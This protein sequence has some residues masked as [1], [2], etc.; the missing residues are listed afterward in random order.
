[1]N[2]EQLASKAEHIVR[3]SKGQP[4]ALPEKAQQAC[5]AYAKIK[6]TMTTKVLSAAGAYRGPVEVLAQGS[7][8]CTADAGAGVLVFCSATRP[9]GGWLTGAMAQEEAVSRASTWALSCDNPRFYSDKGND[10]YFYKNAV[11]SVAGK[12]F[13]RNNT[14]LSKPALVHFVGMCAPNARAMEEHHQHPESPAM[15]GRIV[16]ALVLRMRMALQAFAQAECSTIVLGAVGCGVF[17]VQLEDCV[18]A[19]DKALRLDGAPFERV[20]F[21]L[22]PNPSADMKKAFA[23]LGNAFVPRASEA[24]FGSP[25][26]GQ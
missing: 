12:V 4:S 22:G 14:P 9:G 18:Q 15:R 24:T 25:N 5:L 3:A 21:G 17:R 26:M 16:D 10:G 19:W 13:E 7:L 1:M 2:R 11:L 6:A 8:E 20:V 23:G